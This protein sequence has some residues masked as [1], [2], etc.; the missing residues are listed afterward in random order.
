MFELILETLETCEEYIPKLIDAT[1]TIAYHFQSGN[2]AAGVELLHP[3]F[4]GIGWVIEAVNGIQQN[5]CQLDI[6]LEEMNELLRTLEEALEIRDYVQMADLFEYEI[7]PMLD[8]WLRKIQD[9]RQ[10]LKMM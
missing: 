10:Q 6:Q 1:T 2:E 5:R 7:A 8:S 3:V 4:E 9:A